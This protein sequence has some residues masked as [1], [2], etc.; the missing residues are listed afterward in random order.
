MNASV[1]YVVADKMGGIASLNSNL[2]RNRPQ[3]DT[4]QQLAIRLLDK[5]YCGARIKG[6]LGANLEVT[7]EYSSS[8]N[9]YSVF[10]R[11]RRAIP[12]DEG[13]LVSNNWEELALYSVYPTRRTIFQIVHDEFNFRLTQFYHPIVGV[14]IAHTRYYYWKLIR[15]FP[16]RAGRI[17][18]LP[19]GIPLAPVARWPKPGPLRLI[20]LG[21]LDGGK[22]IHDLPEL[23]RLVQEAG[24]QVHW[25]VIGDGPERASL[26][27]KWPGTDRVRYCSPATN[28][29]VLALCSEGDVFVLP[30]RFEGL[31][32]ALLEAMSAGLV[33]VV[34][35]LASGI[36]EVVT[37]EVG[38]RPEVGDCRA[39]A[40]AIIALANDRHRLEA[41]SLAARKQARRF[42]VAE[43]AAAYHR[44]FS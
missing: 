4:V 16:N 14:M 6:N 15:E 41:M 32:V 42:D 11:L 9:A 24:V 20:F 38:F 29:E 44:L 1:I 36:P 37:D 34:T 26:Q 3:S 13:A 27:S 8:E 31:P 23:D 30:T 33:P 18:H 21:R 5:N 12:S 39:F 2:I 22:G 28:E 10:R 25:T 35:N 17:F 40:E 7:F 19:Y 43:R